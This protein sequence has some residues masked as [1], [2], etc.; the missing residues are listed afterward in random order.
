[1]SPFFKSSIFHKKLK[2]LFSNYL[3]VSLLDKNADC[4]FLKYQKISDLNSLIKPA[5]LC[6]KM[7]S[8][9]L[10]DVF[11]TNDPQSGG[12][13]HSDFIF[14]T[15]FCLN[16][17]AG[18]IDGYVCYQ[19]SFKPKV[20]ESD[21]AIGQIFKIPPMPI[22]QD[23]K[24]QNEILE[25]MQAHPDCP[26]EFIKTTHS[27]VEDLISIVSKIQTLFSRED[28]TDSFL[29]TYQK[30]CKE[31][32]LSYM[33]SIPV[34]E[35][36]ETLKL[37]DKSEIKIKL[38]IEEDLLVYDFKGTTLG[39][40]L[41]L[42]ESMTESACYAT[43]LAL[44]NSNLPVTESILSVS[45]I[46]IPK[47]SLLNANSQQYTFWGSTQGTQWV[48][49]LCLKTIN[50]IYKK[51]N[52]ESVSA[53][54]GASTVIDLQFEDGT[55]Y[56]QNLSSGAPATALS[57]GEPGVNIWVKSQLEESIEQTENL[58]PIKIKSFSQRPNSAG[59]G[60]NP[61]GLGVTQ[62]IQILK[63][64]K[65]YWGFLPEKPKGA[66][67]GKDAQ[68]SDIILTLPTGE[69][70]KLS[71]IGYANCPAQSQIVLHSP[72]GGGFGDL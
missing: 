11:L 46:L 13:L 44:L 27:I 16:N 7:M 31:Q 23:F 29:K 58:F 59:E 18:N 55:H 14:I 61:G 64:A 22:A 24:L 3:Q 20:I 63:P 38:S 25:S 65:L 68:T 37:N 15:P 41:Y 10:G 43:T 6:Q 57:K 53:V 35:A 32:F 36:T 49:N 69:R 48:S 2:Y 42:T 51:H 21:T 66:E 9:K 12:S 1:M 34:G 52:K 71:Y 60:E 45:Q 47:N 33:D 50:Q 62:V 26:D 4:L 67:G 72:G 39:Q 54:S 70:N 40:D 5:K 8:A 30:T 17:S 28:F 56:Y 19:F